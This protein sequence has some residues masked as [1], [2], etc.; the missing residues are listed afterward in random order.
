MPP[1]SASTDVPSTSTAN[2]DISPWSEYVR[3][4]K[5][6]MIAAQQKMAA[7]DV[8]TPAGRA[9][10]IAAANEAHKES[11]AVV[12][13][14]QTRLHAHAEKIS[15]IGASVK[16]TKAPE[17]RNKAA[18]SSGNTSGPR[19]RP[20]VDKI[21]VSKVQY[22]RKDFDTGKAAY[23]KYIAKTLDVM[24]IT[25]PQ[26][27]RNWTRGLLTAASRESRFRPWAANTDPD[28]FNVMSSGN[29]KGP[30]GAPVNSSRGGLQTIPT[31]FAAHHQAGTSNNIYDPVAN[32]AAAMNYVMSR[33]GVDRD[34]SDKVSQ[35]D[36]DDAPRGY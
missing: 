23:K 7:V 30:D 12:K 11:T 31:T 6:E 16:V 22:K 21:P 4:A 19:R 8:T 32:A 5:S 28:D 14:L 20:D 34:G 9:A 10:A 17:A 1:P 35:F 3:T 15:A 24:G 33:Y 29:K 13:E 27:R 18:V 25:D 2:T 26:A 36:P